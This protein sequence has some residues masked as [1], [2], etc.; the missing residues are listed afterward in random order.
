MGVLKQK[1]VLDDYAVDYCSAIIIKPKEPFINWLKNVDDTNDDFILNMA[2]DK[3]ISYIK[4]YESQPV[5][6]W[7][8]KIIK[9]AENIG[10]GNFMERYWIPSGKK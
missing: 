6:S 5:D 4:Q 1:F 3:K 8:D 9:H 7:L 10:D 2:R